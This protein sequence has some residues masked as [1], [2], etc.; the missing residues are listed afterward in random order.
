MARSLHRRRRPPR[1][2]SCARRRTRRSARPTWS[3]CGSTRWPTPTWPARWPGRTRPVIVTCR[4][5]WEGGHFGGSEEARLRLLEQALARRRRL[6]RR[7]VGGA[8]RRALDRSDERRAP[9]SVSSTTSPACRPIW[10]R[11]IARCGR[12]PRAVVKIA[13][14]APR[15]GRLLPLRALR[16]ARPAGA[17]SLLAMGRPAPSRG[18]CR[19]RFGSAW[20]YA[21]DGVGAGTDL[22]RHAARRVPASARSVAD[23]RSTASSPARRAFRLAGDAQRRVSRRRHRRRVRAAARRPMPPTCWRLPRRST[24]AAPASRCRSRS[25]S[26]PHVAADDAVARRVGAVNTLVRDGRAVDGIQHRRRRTSSR[27]S[28]GA[29]DSNGAR[30]TILGAGGAARGAASRLRTPGARVTMHA[31]RVE[32]GSRRGQRH[33]RRHAADAAGARQL[34]SAGQ[35][36]VGW[37]GAAASTRRRGPTPGSTGGSSTT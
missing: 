35:R 25:T 3:S 24:C 20:T 13:V 6:R 12:R 5:A 31:R 4:A 14:T 37:H 32:R 17:R 11:C 29:S 19:D 10:R 36:H 21:G 8:R 26:L 1:S 7:R 9:D 16:A 15:A 2:P 18:S 23:A 33:G 22:R 30:A 28:T 34:G 27:R